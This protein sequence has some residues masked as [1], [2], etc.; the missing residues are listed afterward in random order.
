MREELRS[1][2]FRGCGVASNS[3]C[4]AAR[5]PHLSKD[6]VWIVFDPFVRGRANQ[7]PGCRSAAHAVG[8]VRI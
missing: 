3:E 7:K 1:P 8:I 5:R 2:P 6:E 4:D